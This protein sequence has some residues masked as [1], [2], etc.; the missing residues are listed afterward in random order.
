MLVVAGARTFAQGFSM[1]KKTVLA[2]LI[3]TLLAAPA[4]SAELRRAERPIPGSYI[5]VF[6]QEAILERMARADHPLAAVAEAR[7]ARLRGKP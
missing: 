3:G 4:F 6:K 7:L 1:M 5:V 2:A